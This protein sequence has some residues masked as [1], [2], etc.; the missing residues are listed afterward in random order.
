MTCDFSSESNESGNVCY[1]DT[2]HGELVRWMNENCEYVEEL[3]CW[4]GEHFFR[5]WASIEYWV[6]FCK[7]R[8]FVFHPCYIGADCS[9]IT[10]VD[11]LVHILD[12]TDWLH[13]LETEHAEL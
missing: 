6:E 9:V 7:R 12:T 5:R 3:K 10:S 8:G 4:E 11:D 2:P 13:L 1:D